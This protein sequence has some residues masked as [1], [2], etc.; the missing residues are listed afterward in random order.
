[1]AASHREGQE[2]DAESVDVGKMRSVMSPAIAATSDTP[3]LLAAIPAAPDPDSIFEAFDAWATGTYGSLYPAQTEALIEIASGANVVVSTPTGSGKS[4][5]ALGAHF[6]ALASGRRSYYT[7]PIKALVSE[8]FFSLVEL[9]GAWNVGM[10]TGD[11]TVNPTAPIICATAEILA[12]QALRAGTDAGADVVVMDEFHYYA[13]PQRG[14]A[15]QVPLLELTTTQFVLMSATLGDTSRLEVD[16][17]ECTGRATAAITSVERP[18]P[19]TFRYV[20][21]PIHE[22]IEE[23]LN[24]GQAPIY[25]VHFTQA[26]RSSERRR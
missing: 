4:L 2:V 10:M 17:S 5:I 3:P 26:L 20:L 1:M 15:W 14:W 8:K 25:V 19:L 23:L 7:A 9:F 11:A 21:T 12:N 18:V 22:T 13:D 6:A 24:G 16:L